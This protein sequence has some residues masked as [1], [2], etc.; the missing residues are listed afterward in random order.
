MALHHH[1]TRLKEKPEHI[2]QRVALGAS[3]GV[4]GVVAAVWL[5]AL[6]ASGTLS[7]S[8]PVSGV[9]A[10][11]GGNSAPS[12]SA[13]AAEAQA[14]PDSIS[15][16]VGAAA[17]AVTGASSTQADPNLTVVDGGTTSSL[18]RTSSANNTSATIIPF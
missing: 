13:Q 14:H 10:S 5:V 8:L 6:I 9:L 12:A 16:L 18:D 1:I 3:V 17:A 11:E 7:L 4:T 2:R 15:N